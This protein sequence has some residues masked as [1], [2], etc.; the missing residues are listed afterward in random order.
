M[1]KLSMLRY[2]PVLSAFVLL[3]A[4]GYVYGL[5][6]DRWKTSRELEQAVECLQRVP[7]RLGDW[8]GTDGTIADRE[9]QIARIAGY[10]R[11]TYHNQRTGATVSVLLVCGR[12]GPI[13]VHTPDICY[14][15]AGFEMAEAISTRTLDCGSGSPAAE[16]FT[17]KFVKRTA[18]VQTN[19]RLFWC[20]S[21]QGAWTAPANP[22]LSFAALPALYKLYVS[23]EMSREDERV[24]EDA[25]LG[26][27]QQFLPELQK[28]LF[29]GASGS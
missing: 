24:E 16:C 23:H 1:P 14:R 2:L 20:W 21:G 27:M 10:V 19:L 28:A 22:R 6:T 7:S 29:S 26:F 12:P 17:S 9:L 11:R 15:G 3:L 18:T 4:S 13:S 25:G 5:R 8:E